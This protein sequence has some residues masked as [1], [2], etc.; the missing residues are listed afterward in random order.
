M[1][2]I[3]STGKKVPEGAAA[4]P[5]AWKLLVVDD[6]PDVRQLTTI[7][8]RNFEFSGRELQLLQADSAAQAKLVLQT[9]PWR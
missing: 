7:S 4:R 6:E 8:L 1:K 2:I 5:N 9:L 3:R